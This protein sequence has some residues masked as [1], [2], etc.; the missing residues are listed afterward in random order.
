[1]EHGRIVLDGDAET[2]KVNADV[3]EFYLGLTG[4]GS[5]L[6]DVGSLVFDVHLLIEP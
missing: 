4:S 2:L 5:F 1:M 3:R 6:F